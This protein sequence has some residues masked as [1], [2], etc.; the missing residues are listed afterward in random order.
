VNKEEISDVIRQSIQYE[1]SQVLQVGMAILTF[2]RNCP[3]D[4]EEFRE[5]GLIQEHTKLVYDLG[6]ALGGLYNGKHH[7]IPDYISHP[8]HSLWF[9]TKNTYTSAEVLEMVEK[10]FQAILENNSKL[11]D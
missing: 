4:M 9:E 6:N 2:D 3:H 10:M 7:R 1:V 8:L 11:F 5:Y